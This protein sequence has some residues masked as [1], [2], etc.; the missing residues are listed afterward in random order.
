M[1][2]FDVMWHIVSPNS[3]FRQGHKIGTLEQG[4]DDVDDAAT[5]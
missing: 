4:L 5:E 3:W 1:L 2:Q